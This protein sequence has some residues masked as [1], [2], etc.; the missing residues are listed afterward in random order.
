MNGKADSGSVNSTC[1]SGSMPPVSGF[2]GD[3]GQ[4]NTKLTGGSVP[5]VSGDSS[6]KCHTT[7]CSA[8]SVAG[9]KEGSPNDGS[10]PTY[11]V[12][13]PERMPITS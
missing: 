4:L 1:Q 12:S 2:K 5:S 9:C 13:G 11:T 3:T 6:G 7:K 8:P 10:N